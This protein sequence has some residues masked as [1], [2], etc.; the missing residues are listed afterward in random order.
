MGS[1]RKKSTNRPHSSKIGKFLSEME[2]PCTLQKSNFFSV[3]KWFMAD[4]TWCFTQRKKEVIFDVCSN[5]SMTVI[6]DNREY[7]TKNYVLI[8]H[9]IFCSRKLKDRIQITI[10]RGFVILLTLRII[11][12]EIYI[13]CSFTLSRIS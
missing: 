12:A 4:E 3:N 9:K 2:A 8:D 7:Q 11:I 13:H 1:Q 5:F 6:Q 10:D